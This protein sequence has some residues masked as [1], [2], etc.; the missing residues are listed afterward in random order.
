M[1]V[2]EEAWTVVSAKPSIEPGR[3]VR[4]FGL[5]NRSDLN[6]LIGTI[7]APE[8]G[9]R[10]AVKVS[11]QPNDE[12]VEFINIKPT[13][14]EVLWDTPRE[15]VEQ[16]LCP[17]C[18][19]TVIDTSVGPKRNAGLQ[20][21]CGKAICRECFKASVLSG[22]NPD[23]CPLCGADTSDTSNEKI[24]S[25]LKRLA[26]QGNAEGQY[27]IAYRYDFGS[28]GIPKNQQKARSLYKAAANQNHIKAAYNLACC[29]R[30][31][32]GGPVDGPAAIQYFLQAASAGHVKAMT[33]LGCIYINGTLPGVDRDLDKAV[34]WLERG[35]QAGDEL[36]VN[37]LRKA[38]L[39]LHVTKLGIGVAVRAPPT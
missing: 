31:G 7:L 5:K 15:T 1:S 11:K 13:N 32:E 18:K 34:Q 14:F 3:Q 35:A 20:T 24:L 16:V 19:V 4:I 17:L 2:E 8:D 10:V 23:L 12:E 36:A 25:D 6:A 27:Q 37:E 30:N 21:C 39:M 29:Y 38:K 33:N 26:E 22:P 28:M 9:G